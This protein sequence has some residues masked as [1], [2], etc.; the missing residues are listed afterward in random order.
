MANELTVAQYTAQLSDMISKEISIKQKS[1]LTF[2][3]GYDVT[4]AL[5]SAMYMIKETVDADKRP[6]LSVC[7]PD[8]IKQA[9]IDM[10]TK[11]LDPNKKHVY[12]IVYANKLSMTESYFGLVYRMKRADTNIV[13][14]PAQVVYEKDTISYEIVD[15]EKR[16]TKHEQ[17]PDNIDLS[18]IK[19]AY[20]TIKYK[21]GHIVSEYMTMAQIKVSW[22]KTRSKGGVQNEFPD[23]MAK[24]TVLKRLANITLNT[25]TNDILLN[26]A[27]AESIDEEADALEATEILELTP[28][29]PEVVQAVIQAAAQVVAQEQTKKAPPKKETPQVELDIPDCL[30]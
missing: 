29:Q 15:A 24:R 17:S 11:G 27:Y 10:A 3:E 5:V 19:G 26:D 23:M 1:G 8:S 7:T 16:I 13:S 12:F 25:E 22:S 18:K 4:N 30:K 2:P 28:P 20:A 21:D 9:V 14:C 6:A